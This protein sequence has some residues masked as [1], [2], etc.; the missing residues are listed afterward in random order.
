MKLSEAIKTIRDIIDMEEAKG[1]P[2]S[3]EYGITKKIFPYQEVKSILQ[4]AEESF[5]V[6]T[7]PEVEISN[8]NALETKT[9]VNLPLDFSNIIVRDN[10]GNVLYTIDI[11][12]LD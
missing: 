8:N 10:E 3:E 4:F 12:S 6:V 11:P 5:F 2:D 7:N 9:N 1:V